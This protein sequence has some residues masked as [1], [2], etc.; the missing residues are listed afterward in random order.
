MFRFIEAKQVSLIQN[1]Q[2]WTYSDQF[3]L[4]KPIRK[5]SKHKINRHRSRPIWCTHPAKCAS[6]SE[7][8][9]QI[10]GKVQRASEKNAFA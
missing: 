7:A 3:Q 6:K 2:L 5:A 10:S 8:G 1:Y 4:L 9:A